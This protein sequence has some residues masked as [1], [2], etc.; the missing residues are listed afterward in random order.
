MEA[1]MYLNKKEISESNAQLKA[2]LE[3]FE[4]I[5]VFN[6]IG[7]QTS[8]VAACTALSKIKNSSN[9]LVIDEA[10]QQLKLLMERCRTASDKIDRLTRSGSMITCK[11]MNC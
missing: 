4:Q 6:E 2:L 10:I 7:Y 3:I 5:S 8:Q 9:A 11:A 1:M